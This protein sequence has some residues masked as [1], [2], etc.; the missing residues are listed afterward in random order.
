MSRDSW[1][2]FASWRSWD[3]EY[4]VPQGLEGELR[5][6][7]LEFGVIAFL[8]CFGVMRKSDFGPVLISLTFPPASSQMGR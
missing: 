5:M 1:M 6:R 4:M 3:S 2:T 7:S 8:S